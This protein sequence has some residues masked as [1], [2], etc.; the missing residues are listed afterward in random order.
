MMLHQGSNWRGVAVLEVIDPIP[1][2]GMLV[3]FLPG[4]TAYVRRALVMVPLFT[5]M[6]GP[7]QAIALTGLCSAVA[8]SSGAGAATLS[9]GRG[10]AACCRAAFAISSA[11]SFWSM[12]TRHSKVMHG[13]FVL[14]PLSF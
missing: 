6:I 1:F 8:L 11:P 10:G 9:G 14:W 12:R 2:A 4:T 5:L 7:V 3:A 13:R